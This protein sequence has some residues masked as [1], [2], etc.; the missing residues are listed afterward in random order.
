MFVL[1]EY[2]AVIVLAV[3][4]SFAGS[5]ILLLVLTRS[6]EAGFLDKAV[7]PGAFAMPPAWPR[8]RLATKMADRWRAVRLSVREHA[9]LWSLRVHLGSWVTSRWETYAVPSQG[10]NREGDGKE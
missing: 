6:E 5:L 10:T 3:L 7:S 4:V 9:R 2:L 1:E 8:L